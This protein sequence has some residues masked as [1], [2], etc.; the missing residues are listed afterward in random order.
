VKILVCAADENGC[1]YYRARWPAEALG[2]EI[3]PHGADLFRGHFQNGPRGKLVRVEMLF[4]ADVIVV[5]R[6][7]QKWLAEAIP[8]IQAQGIAVVVEIDDD[9]TC[10]DP[11][12]SA[13][14]ACQPQTSPDR[15]W[16]HLQDAA[17]QADLVT[18]S[19][20]ALAR[21]FAPHGRVAVLPNCIPE[22]YLTQ[23]H[24]RMLRGDHWTPRRRVRVGW[25]GSVASHPGDLNVCGRGV[26]NA[27]DKS[28]AAFHVIGTGAG[29][30]AALDIRDGSQTGWVELSDYPRELARLDVGIVPLKA[31]A[32]NR[33]KSWLKGLEMAACG[34]PFVASTSPEYERLAKLGAG[35][36][37]AKPRD[38]E[39]EAGRMARDAYFREEEKARAYETAKTL[40]IEGNAWRWHAAWSEAGARRMAA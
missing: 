17:R 18:V 20:A 14:R 16:H 29:V 15:N 26:A 39:R 33:A 10:I 24:A 32:F 2:V 23:P 40:T 1:G 12:N 9:F 19:T 38:W 37:A 5:Q 4:D 25:S 6:P 11:A 13:W 21:R 36:L 28:N 30:P 27:V 35:R 8:L 31:S 3:K 34:V 7:L 22:S